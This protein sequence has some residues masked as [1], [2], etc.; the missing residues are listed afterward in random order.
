MEPK[1]KV[2]DQAIYKGK[3]VTITDIRCL[4]DELRNASFHYMVHGAYGYIYES[5]LTPVEKCL[6]KPVAVVVM[7]ASGHTCVVCDDGSIWQ[8][9]ES[10]TWLEGEPIPGTKRAKEK[11]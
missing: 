4:S 5:E 9:K 1:F 7:Q 10:G 6:R 2:N 11:A 8:H 3:I